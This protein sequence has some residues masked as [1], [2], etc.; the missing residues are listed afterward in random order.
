MQVTC[1]AKHYQESLQVIYFSPLGEPQGA[2]QFA[3]HADSWGRVDNIDGSK[4]QIQRS[5]TFMIQV[6]I[7]CQ[8]T[9]YFRNNGAIWS[10]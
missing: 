3:G 10:P 4:L 1:S 7:Y 6:H 9:M 5:F 2:A 8:R